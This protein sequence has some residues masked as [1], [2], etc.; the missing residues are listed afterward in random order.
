MGGGAGRLSADDQ[1]LLAM[2]AAK[3]STASIAAILGGRWSEARVYNRLAVLREIERAAGVVATV[4]PCRPPIKA[5]RPS[6]PPL[7][8][9]EA[10][11]APAAAS[12]APPTRKVD[13]SAVEDDVIRR[14][15][16]DHPGHAASAACNVLSNRTLA[17]IRSRAHALGLRQ[18]GAARTEYSPPPMQSRQVR[19]ERAVRDR[20]LMQVIK[21]LSP[22][23]LRFAGWFHVAGW[24]ADEIADLFDLDRD[25]LALALGDGA[26]IPAEGM[27]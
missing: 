3:M 1:A 11:T 8:M 6:M 27:A 9:T 4:A 10:S 23:V 7:R 25:Q 24:P 16:R 15:W 21:P 2:W 5:P 14:C 26:G 18:D 17:S 13:F 20:P 12:P 19:R 22:R